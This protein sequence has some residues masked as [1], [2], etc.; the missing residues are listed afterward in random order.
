MSWIYHQAFLEKF[1]TVCF[2]YTVNT[3]ITLTF[4]L[5]L[6]HILSLKIY[7]L[8]NLY[9]LYKYIILNI[10]YNIYNLCTYA[11]MYKLHSCIF[12]EVLE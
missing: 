8:F 3:H 4:I 11:C 6:C 1:Q 10:I 5:T 9:N 12:V 7:M 2:N